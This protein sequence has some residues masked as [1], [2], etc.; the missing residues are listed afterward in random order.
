M[1]VVFLPF[2]TLNPYQTE[3]AQALEDE[4]VTILSFSP[5]S[6]LPMLSC[7][8]KTPQVDIVHLHW[9][10]GFL[11][12]DSFCRSLFW[13]TLFLIEVFV[14]KLFG[15]KLVWTVHNLL[16]HERKHARLELFYLRK[17]VRFCDEII[18][19]SKYAQ[20]QVIDAFCVKKRNKIQV[21]PH[22][23]YISSYP[24]TINQ[25]E[26]RKLLHLDDNKK[27]FLYFGQV[28]NYKG[29]DELLSAFEHPSLSESQLVIAGHPKSI[30][31][32]KHLMTR[33]E[34]LD[35]VQCFF[36]FISVDYVQ[37]FMNAADAVV[38]P[39]R[40]IFTSGSVMLAMSFG[41]PIIIPNV[42]SLSEII[43]V[44][45]GMS[46]DPYCAESLLK[47][48]QT[49]S[50][51]DPIQSGEANCKYATRYNWLEIAKL[52]KQIYLHR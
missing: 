26:A 35:N 42:P 20:Q 50:V 19:H 11:V 12:K 22:G 48:L 1:K 5:Y 30:A 49:F 14:L 29:V 25:K 36:E 7:L 15:K 23:H 51:T 40:D 45:D 16:D 6:S 46:Y 47:T 34:R 44:M 18:V 8:W 28:R 4:G 17:I 32:K 3:L 31:Y 27:V 2:D 33:V 21:V 10:S 41:R 38:F 43:D 52:T 9:L 13:S 39:F 24:N 37:V